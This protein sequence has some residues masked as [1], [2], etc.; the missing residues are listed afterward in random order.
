M[1]WITW[2]NANWSQLSAG[3]KLAVPP[4][5]PHPGRAGFRRLSVGTPHGQVAD[6]G[7]SFTDGSR[8]HLHQ[9]ADGA[10]VAHR[11]RWDPDST[12]GRLLAHILLE[13]FAGPMLVAAGVVA[14]VHSR[15]A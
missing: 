15:R 1:S 8:V 4:W 5:L 3:F 7:L 9:F 2:I 13:T 11:D 10:I 14:A 6:W 12:L